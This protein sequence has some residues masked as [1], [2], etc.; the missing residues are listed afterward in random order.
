MR[1][2][3]ITSRHSILFFFHIFIPQQRR[4]RC[5]AKPDT[6]VLRD[7]LLHGFGAVEHACDGSEA[8]SRDGKISPGTCQ[9]F[10]DGISRRCAH[11]PLRSFTFCKGKKF[12]RK[13]FTQ[14]DLDAPAA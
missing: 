10:E 14:F 9:G 3:W 1:Y 2:L 5:R 7:I 12:D 4:N 11:P 8:Q 6:S 13:Q